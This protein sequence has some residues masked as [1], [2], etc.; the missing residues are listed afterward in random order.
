MHH[1]LHSEMQNADDL[2]PTK[3]L[4]VRVKHHSDLRLWL[5]RVQHMCVF[6][7]RGHYENKCIITHDGAHPK[8]L[9]VRQ[10][11]R[12]HNDA[13]PELSHNVATSP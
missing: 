6:S 4:S 5:V 3:T 11:G 10:A 2:D 7:T 12:E 9:A 1:R 13:P 8:Q